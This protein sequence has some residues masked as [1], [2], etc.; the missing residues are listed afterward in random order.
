MLDQ[1]TIDLLSSLKNGR[2]ERV[3]F[4]S[5]TS[6]QDHRTRLTD[7][8]LVLDDGRTVTFEAGYDTIDWDINAEY[9][10]VTIEQRQE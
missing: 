7:V 10:E 2:I 3:D 9:L 8:S 4:R 1:A 6:K 5:V